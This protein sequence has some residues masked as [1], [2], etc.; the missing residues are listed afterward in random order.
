[1]QEDNAL[2]I[3]RLSYFYLSYLTGENIGTNLE[4]SFII[5]KVLLPMVSQLRK[6]YYTVE[7][8]IM[9]S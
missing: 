1:M 9:K 3:N 8:S 2:I 5:R 6:D 4:P 7:F